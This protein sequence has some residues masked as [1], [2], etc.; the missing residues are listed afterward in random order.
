MHVHLHIIVFLISHMNSSKA[1]TLLSLLCLITGLPS[2]QA[3][4]KVAYLAEFNTGFDLCELHEMNISYGTKIGNI[5]TLNLDQE[6]VQKLHSFPRLLL[7]KKAAKVYP[8]LKRAI[9]DLRADSVCMATELETGYTGKDVIIG[10]TDWGFDYTHP[11]FYD[12]ALQETRILAAW[13]QFKTSGPHPEGYTYG[14]MHEGSTELMQ[15]E[16]DTFNVYEYAT[17]GSHVAGIAGGGGAGIGLKGV[18][19]DANFLMVTFLINEAAV[20]DGIAWMKKKADQYKKRLVINMSWGLYNFGT[21]DG[22]SLL[23]KALDS[24]SKQ[25]VVF[26]TSGGNN[27]DVNF[28]IKHEFTGTSIDTISTGIAFYP[29][30]AHPKMW[31]QSISIWGQ[32]GLAFGFKMILL[33]QSNDIVFESETFNTRLFENYLDTHAVVG[34]DTVFYNISGSDP[35]PNPGRPT[36]RFRVQNKTNNL[37]VGIKV[38]A[39][40]GIVHLHNVVELTNGVGNWGLPFTSIKPGWL[41][42]DNAYGLGEPASNRSVIT[43]AAHVPEIKLQSGQIAGGGLANFSSRGPTIDERSKPDISGPG[44]DIESS[45]SSF[46]TR[47]YTLTRNVN[48]K[49]KDFPMARFSGTSMSSPATAGVVAMMLQANSSLS[50]EQVKFILKTTARQ[51]LRTGVIGDTASKSWGWGKVNALAA[52]QMAERMRPSIPS[53]SVPPKYQI[54]PNPAKDKLFFSGDWN[55]VYTATLY[56]LKGKIIIT[57]MIGSHTFLPLGHIQD[58][59][60]LLKIEGFSDIFRVVLN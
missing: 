22:T 59:F 44:V 19:Y 56:D 2:A 14:T 58:G 5:V 46:T 15:A 28:H 34:L 36:F 24:F 6:D 29:F 18:A 3:Q 17:H 38:I 57:G 20:I 52:V 25:G 49:G 13:D 7:L 42:G 55:S 12:T 32:N 4:S 33:N 50:A 48:F 21:L 40:M 1:F 47:D 27:G 16:K 60:Y 30:N 54:Y 31:G 9:P 37:R 45:I 41:N 35:Y 11:M 39:A 8:E 26:V 10:V 51:D 23:S 53:D 43:V